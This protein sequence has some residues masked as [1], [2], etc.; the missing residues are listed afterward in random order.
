MT[1][2]EQ[3]AEAQNV[4]K[5]SNGRMGGKW[6]VWN[7]QNNVGLYLATRSACVAFVEQQVTKET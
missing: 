4:W 1:T 7:T 5:I 2:A 6:M 3:I